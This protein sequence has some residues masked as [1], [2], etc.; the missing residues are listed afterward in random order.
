M[1]DLNLA[2]IGNCTQAA[3]ID[4][5][6]RIA[7]C[8]M[9][10]LDGDPVFCSLL[11][12][13]VSGKVGGKSKGG[14]DDE[15]GFFEIAVEDFAHSEQHYRPNTA[16]LATTLYDS[17]GQAVEVVDF[18]PRFR[19]FGRTHRPATLIRRVVPL[20]GNPRIRIR[21]RPRFGY[22]EI[23][24]TVTRG[25]NHMRFAS[26]DAA[27]RL[28]TDAPI[29]Y[30]SEETLFVLETPL[31]L[32]FGDDESLTAP[33]AETVRTFLEETEAY[34][35][36]F[37]RY[38]ALPFEWQDAVIRAAI[39]LK[40]CSFEETGAIVAALTT[41]IPESP[42]SERNWDYRYCWLRDSY[43][44]VHA[45]NRLGATKTME[46]YLH[47]ITNIVADSEDGYL[48]PLFSLTL[49]NDMDERL[50]G[51]LTGYRGM[52]PVR[53]GNAAHSQVQNDSYGA[54]VLASA[55]AF[56]DNRLE[57]PGTLRLFERLELLGEQAVKAWNTPDAG[58][59]ELR[60]RERVHTFSAVMCWAACDRLAKIARRL[61]LADRAERWMGDADRIR[62][63]IMKKAFDT[64]QNSFVESF[65]G[66]DI[67]AALL[68]IHELG[69]IAADDP[70]FVGTVAA[71][72]KWLKRGNLIY[73]YHAADDFGE[74]EVAFTICTFWYIDALAAMEDRREE[75]RALF[76]QMLSMRNHVGLLSEDVD[77]TTNELWG[78]FPQTY[79]MVG[80]INSA[81][82]LSKAWEEAF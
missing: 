20:L 82:K 46:D 16:V 41:S 28:T 38:L 24:P 49:H 37:T 52:G 69:F 11:N 32:V 80:L 7:W 50:C 6:S 73:R 12:S 8:C 43:F 1:P 54:V 15:A 39:T 71:V 14:P 23:E 53:V 22:G 60:T 77:P 18:A 66:K 74:P 2:I 25:S 26:P 34:W 81:M 47:Y 45:L 33:V 55:Q 36:E 42:H 13:R 64:E 75:A 65:G 9:P 29:S 17:Q 21:L 79:S 57:R 72:E 27:R 68:L 56:F 70:R 62:A 4:R 59:W 35:R 31:H 19:Q 51:H 78:N 40:L 3:L 5:R 61:G 30:I 48:K 63:A 44:V 58:L 10:R 67:D 76:E